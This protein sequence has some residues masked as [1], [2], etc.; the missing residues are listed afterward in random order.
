MSLKWLFVHKPSLEIVNLN[1]GIGHRLFD[2]KVCLRGEG[3]GKYLHLRSFLLVFPN[4]HRAADQG[5]SD[6]VPGL[7]GQNRLVEVEVDRR[8]VVDLRSRQV[9]GSLGHPEVHKT[10]RA[11]QVD[12]AVGQH[13]V[14]ELK[15]QHSAVADREL[16]RMAGSAR[17][18]RRQVELRR[19]SVEDQ[20]VKSR[21]GPGVLK[22]DAVFELGFGF[23]VM[24][25]IVA[26]RE[27]LLVVGIEGADVLLAID[28]CER[29]AFIF[30]K[31]DHEAGVRPVAAAFDRHRRMAGIGEAGYLLGD[32]PVG[33]AGGLQQQIEL[34]AGIEGR[35]LV[36][37]H[38]HVVFDHDVV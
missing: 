9:A 7:I 15:G 28:R 23:D 21:V 4:L 31:E 8:L 19:Q 14:G 20:H 10:L 22:A 38:D 36:G 32:D 5:R 18:H 29:T 13:D 6:G 12:V 33:A 26:V 3:V 25:A 34:S 37:V 2:P 27:G 24:G 11:G 30:R 1:M 16:V 17:S 35:D